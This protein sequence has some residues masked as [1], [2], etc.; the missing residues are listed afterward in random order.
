[1]SLHHK[2]AVSLHNAFIEE[3]QPCEGG[4]SVNSGVQCIFTHSDPVALL[5]RSSAH[6]FLIFVLFHFVLPS[7]FS[8]ITTTPLKFRANKKRESYMEERK[9]GNWSLVDSLAAYIQQTT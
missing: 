4:G 7:T 8:C 5:S 9:R 2:M 1:M 6:P 3:L